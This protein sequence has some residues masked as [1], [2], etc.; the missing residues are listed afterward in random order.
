MAIKKEAILTRAQRLKRVN[1]N[2]SGRDGVIFQPASELTNVHTER[3]DTGTYS[4]NR[5]FNGGYPCGKDII[6]AGGPGSGKDLTINLAIAAC[7]RTKG[8]DATIAIVYTEGEWDKEFARMVGCKVSYSTEEITKLEEARGIT[9]S[10]SEKAS[11]RKEGVGFIG[12]YTVSNAADALD[13]LLDF[14]EEG[15]FDIVVLNSIDG[16]IVP[17]AEEAVDAGGIDDARK[18]RG[19]ERRAAMLSD[20]FRH[21]NKFM[22]IPL[23]VT[24]PKTK[25]IVSVSRKTVFFYISQ[26]R[27]A[28]LNKYVSTDKQI[29]GGQAI[30]FYSAII[31]EISRTKGEETYMGVKKYNSPDHVETSH[32]INY[33]LTKVKYGGADGMNVEFRYYKRDHYN[34]GKLVARGG[35]VDESAA[36]R[37][38][39]AKEGLLTKRGNLAHLLTLPGEDPIEL[40]G[41]RPLVDKWLLEH[42][43]TRIK[44]IKILTE[45]MLQ[46]TTPPDDIEEE[47][48]E[49]VLD[50]IVDG[51]AQE[52]SDD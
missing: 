45:K 4:L 32:I 13:T 16:L 49:E 31:L 36:I 38:S 17:E 51:P 3:L 37:A 5:A 43:D 18:G 40:P 35:V 11:M 47:E 28:H 26:L 12:I 23:E 24:D 27:T 15:I 22:C 2:A 25:K 19:G 29:S 30:R 33:H 14:A 20:F 42:P 34:N 8:N 9:F 6:L 50:D 10:K 21:K 41:A 48:G 52:E 44:A 39:L 7:Q 46:K 1:S